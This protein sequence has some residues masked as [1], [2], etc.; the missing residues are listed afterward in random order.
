MD[1]TTDQVKREK[2]IRILLQWFEIHARDFPWRYEPD[3]YKILISEILLQKTKA[4]NVV[5]V[6]S[7]FIEKYPDIQKLSAATF[8]DIEKDIK[9]LGLSSQRAKNLEMLGKNLAKKYRCEVPAN[10][11]DLLGLPGIGMYISNAVLC[12]AFEMDSPL[13]DTNIGRIIE[14]VFSIKVSGE[15]RKKIKSWEI[16]SQI[17]PKGRARDFNY[18]LIDFG[19]LICKAK[20]PKHHLCPLREICDYYSQ[21][22]GDRSNYRS[23]ILLANF[24]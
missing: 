5:P 6:Y 9:I 19:A 16:I 1:L 8:N 21:F 18:S 13:L 3:P 2:F 11:D 24:I 10:R 20:N 23:H 4:Q 17:I 7:T 12:F 15:E 22:Q 14:R